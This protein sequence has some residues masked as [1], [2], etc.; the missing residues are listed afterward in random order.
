MISWVHIPDPHWQGSK[1]G[2]RI[3]YEKESSGEIDEDY[4]RIIQTADS[5]YVETFELK[6]LDM[7]SSYRFRVAGRN[8]AGHG[9]KSPYHE[10]GRIFL[11]LFIFDVKFVANESCN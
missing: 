1:V 9:V 10:F 3:F 2:Y 8:N 4:P 11:Y 5:G 7:Y 6:G